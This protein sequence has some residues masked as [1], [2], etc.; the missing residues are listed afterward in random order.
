ML[1]DRCSLF[2]QRRQQPLEVLLELKFFG[3]GC[4]LERLLHLAG[5]L[6]HM[7]ICEVGPR[8]RSASVR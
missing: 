3:V 6:I 5:S 7:A 8:K 4:Q 2:V 1:N